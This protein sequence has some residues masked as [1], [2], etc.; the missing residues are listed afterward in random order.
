VAGWQRWIA[1]GRRHWP[2]FVVL[3][4]ALLMRATHLRPM[5]VYGDDAEYVTVARS[6]AH[7]PRALAYPDLEGFGTFPFVSHPPLMLY[8]FAIAGRIVGDVEVGAVL[9]S[10]LLGTATCGLTYA[11]GTHVAGRVN[12]ALAG[13]VLAILPAHVTLSRKAFLDVGL[14]FFMT[15]TI[16][17]ALVWLQRRTLGWAL[18]TGCAAGATALSKLTGVLVFGPL[19]AIFAYA[20]WFERRD[21]APDASAELEAIRAKREALRQG[22]WALVPVAA[23]GLAYLSLVWYLRASRDLFDKLGWQF[24][25]VTATHT[26]SSRAPRAWHWYFTGNEGVFD[27]FTWGFAILALLGILVLVAWL[28]HQPGRR[29]TALLLLVWPLS[30]LI[31]FTLS[32][33]KE[34]FYVLPAAPGLAILAALPFSHALSQQWAWTRR[35]AQWR[36]PRPQATFL[37]A[38]AG[39]L[40]LAL[41]PPAVEAT[42]DVVFEPRSYGYGVKEAAQWIHERDPQAAQIG[43]LLGRFTLKYYN[44]QPT[45]HWY[46]PHEY[47]ESEIQKG[48]VKYVVRDDY[49]KLAY[50]AEWMEQLVASHAG[51]VVQAYESESGRVRVTVYELRPASANATAPA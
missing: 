41:A 36:L 35:L 5:F 2:L 15:L 51:Q 29:A 1:W 13:L 17:F 19:I 43:T 9:V 32:T 28:R 18:A 30:I 14:T 25:R 6:L 47:V 24:G 10:I 49:L 26:G 8:L 46:V 20:Y 11:I 48:H 50:E 21:A 39:L 23:L 31:A 12:G 45:Y 37:A 33:R 34:W 38:L 44:D 16:L 7:D 40:I 22:A 3:L 27:R 4:V 42:R